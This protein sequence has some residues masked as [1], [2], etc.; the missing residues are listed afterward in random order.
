MCT[1]KP[2]TAVRVTTVVG[3]PVILLFD[4]QGSA[5]GFANLIND[6]SDARAELMGPIHELKLIWTGGPEQE[7][8]AEI[9]AGLGLTFDRIKVKDADLVEVRDVVS[10]S[11]AK[12]HFYTA[13]ALW[14]HGVPAPANP[15][16]V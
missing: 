10:T 6:S 5:Q 16:E 9:S 15:A 12:G 1:R 13:R 4:E 8:P 14:V 3:G 7:T 11:D 2:Q